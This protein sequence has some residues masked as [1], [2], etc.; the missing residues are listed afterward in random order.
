M[1]NYFSKFRQ[2]IL[3]SI[4]L[5]VQLLSDDGYFHICYCDDDDPISAF[6]LMSRFDFVETLSE[7]ENIIIIQIDNELKD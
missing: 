2:E 5:K 6:F 3:L 4:P 7:F 1:K